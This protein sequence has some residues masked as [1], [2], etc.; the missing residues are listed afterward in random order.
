VLVPH[1]R[2]D[3]EFGEGRLTPDEI[4]NALVFLGLEP[5]AARQ[6]AVELGAAGGRNDDRLGQGLRLAARDDQQPRG[7]GG[8][9]F[10][11]N[12]VGG[13]GAI[14]EP[15]GM[16]LAVDL[17]QRRNSNCIAAHSRRRA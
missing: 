17:L 11:D 2:E 6:G 7:A 12:P 9:E 13:E 14:L 8:V 3:A 16:G 4:E 10:G 5:W 1:G 15:A